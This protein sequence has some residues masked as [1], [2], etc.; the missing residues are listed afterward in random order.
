MHAKLT[1]SAPYLTSPI[2]LDVV[3]EEDIEN[4]RVLQIAATS[5]WKKVITLSRLFIVWSVGK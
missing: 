3:Q 5:V 1:N 2:L 4:F